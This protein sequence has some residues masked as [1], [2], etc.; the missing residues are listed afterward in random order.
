MY[1]RLALCVVGVCVGVWVLCTCVW[2]SVQYVRLLT[3]SWRLSVKVDSWLQA[4][5]NT[6]QHACLQLRWII[7]HARQLKC[8]TEGVE[9]NDWSKTLEEIAPKI[10]FY[11]SI[12]HLFFLFHAF[13]STIF[14]LL[15]LRSNLFLQLSNLSQ[16]MTHLK[17]LKTLVTLVW[18]SNAAGQIIWFYDTNWILT[19]LKARRVF[20]KWFSIT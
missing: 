5:V 11:S 13:S 18:P 19:E 6:W 15:F 4:G 3:Q 12:F 7:A 14:F 20:L 9:N 10:L 16:L 1:S 8:Q 2:C 17:I